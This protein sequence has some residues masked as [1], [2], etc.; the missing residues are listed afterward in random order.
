[1]DSKQNIKIHDRSL[2]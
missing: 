2:L 1:M